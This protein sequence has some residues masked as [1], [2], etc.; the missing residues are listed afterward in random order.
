MEASATRV[1]IVD[2]DVVISSLLSSLMNK[3]GL[4]NA[5]AHDGETALKMVPVVRPDMLLLDVKMPGIDGM[6]V[7]KRVKEADPHLP[8]VLIT[9]YA[10]ISASVAAIRAGAFDYLAKPFDHS[11]VIRVVRATLAER[12]RRRRSESEGIAADNCLRVMMGPSDAVTRIIREVNRI[13]QSD[14]SVIIQGETGSGKELVA[15]AIWQ[16]SKRA[17]APF[18][19]VDCGA[20]PETLIESELFGY[21]K[22]AFTGAS[23]AKAGKFEA[24]Q[25][26]TLFLD[27]IGNLPLASQMRLLRVLQEKAVLRLGAIKPV[28]VDVRLITASNQELQG[29]VSSGQMRED[30]F[31]RLNEFTITIPPL[32][33]RKDDIPYLAQ[34]FMDLT[35]KELQKNVRR[36]SEYGLEALMSYNWPGNVRQLRSV[37]RRAVLLADDII[38]EYHLDIKRAPVPGLA[39]TPKIQGTPW[40]ELSLREIVQRSVV[41]VERE[42]LVQVMKHTRGNKAKAARLLQ[43]D[44]KTIHT[45]LKQFG[46]KQSGGG[47]D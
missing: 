11:E 7:L 24:A 33:E 5:L 2:D 23:A 8:V 30:L 43:V 3:E 37:I 10:E 28:K 45:K 6:E 22:G 39:F 46:I 40:D 36:F 26:G 29:L 47:H 13:A 31:F 20:I 38:T 32:R 19:P 1:L 18:I 12:E 16:L 25:G 42:V 21:Q 41:T 4:T 34:R 14:F 35:N 27:E 17:D 9:A 15:R 44:Y